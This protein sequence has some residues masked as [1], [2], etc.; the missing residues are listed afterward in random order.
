PELTS[1]GNCNEWKRHLPTVIKG[2][3]NSDFHPI[4]I[5]A[6]VENAR[7]AYQAT[8]YFPDLGSTQLW[9]LGE[10]LIPLLKKD[11]DLLKQRFRH[12]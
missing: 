7:S 6:A 11:L 1:L 2:G 5:E 4:S 8:G 10:E 9:Q 12:Q 3:F